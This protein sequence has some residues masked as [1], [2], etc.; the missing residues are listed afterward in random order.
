MR[1]AQKAPEDD[2]S[3]QRKAA[4]ALTNI[5]SADDE[6]PELTPSGGESDARVASSEKPRLG[7]DARSAWAGRKDAAEA[8]RASRGKQR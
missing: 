3:S 4:L 2:I 7:G 8:T 5:I 1:L 6:R